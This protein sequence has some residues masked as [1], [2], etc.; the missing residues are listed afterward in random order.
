MS[1]YLVIERSISIS[2]EPEDI[3][4]YIN[5]LEE[6]NDWSPWFALDKD[7]TYYYDG[8]ERGKGQI[9]I[10]ESSIAHI[11]NGQQEIIASQSPDFVKTTLFANNQILDVTYA[12]YEDEGEAL[13]QSVVILRTENDLGGF[14][15]LQRIM[16][17]F[18]KAR[19]Y[20][21]YDEALLRL[22]HITEPSE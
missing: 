21:P 11:A 20:G 2:A 16:I 6:M 4:P 8:P 17:H 5:D 22:K 9:A 15:Y 1:P 18:R 3:F 7:A 19:I 12:I 13:G 10:W 14:P